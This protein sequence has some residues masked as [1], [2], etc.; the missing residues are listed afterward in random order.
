MNTGAEHRKK[1]NGYGLECKILSF[2]RIANVFANRILTF[3]NEKSITTANKKRF[4]PTKQITLGHI[5]YAFYL[6]KKHLCYVA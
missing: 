5:N 1:S 3:G 4:K 6:D 2:L